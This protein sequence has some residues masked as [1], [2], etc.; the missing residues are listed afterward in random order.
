LTEGGHTDV[1]RKIYRRRGKRQ[2][3]RR[4]RRR[5]SMR[6]SKRKR[7]LEVATENK[8]IEFLQQNNKETKN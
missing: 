1:Y 4:R 6:K 3:R 7:I 5:T 2:R 8:M